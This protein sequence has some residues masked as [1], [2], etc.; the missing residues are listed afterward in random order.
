MGMLQL[1]MPW[2]TEHWWLA[3]WLAFWALV[4]GYLLVLALVRVPFI[5]TQRVLRAVVVLLRGW[6]TEHLDADGDWKKEPERPPLETEAVTHRV[7]PDGPCVTTTR[8][9][10]KPGA[11]S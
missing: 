3:F 5:L 10:R 1:A 4:F 2:A 9:Y 6:P 8:H 7:T 11:E